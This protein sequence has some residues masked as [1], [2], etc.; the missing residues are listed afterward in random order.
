MDSIAKLRLLTA[1]ME[2]ESAEDNECPKISARKQDSVNLSH[3]TLPNGTTIKL[4]KTLLTSFCER[5]CYYCPFRSGRDFQRATFSP[6]DFADLSMFLYKKRIIDGI[7]LS[8]GII[9]TGTFTQDQLIKTAEIL[10]IKHNFRGYLHLKI[11]PGSDFGQIERAMQLANRVSINLEAPNPEKLEF[12]A[13]KKIFLKELLQP[14]IWINDIRLQQPPYHAWN[15][16]WPSSVTQFV[17]GAGGESDL[18]LLKTTV[19]LYD[20]LNLGRVYYSRFNPIR[21]T[22]LENIPPTPI[23][24]EHRLYQASYLLR[25]YNFSLEELPFSDCGNLPVERDPKLVWAEINLSN[26]PV[27]INKAEYIELLRIPGIGPK[28]AR[29]IINSRKIHPLIFLDDLKR[30]GINQNRAAPY[31]LLNG[32]RPA[33]QYPLF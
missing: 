31:I 23:E 19:Y 17:V 21:D 27:E 24:R 1:Q 32:K 4:L 16:R 15:G 3:A 30:L 7:F 14:L 9:N 5:N 13:P 28:S 22:P 25:D 33:S 6:Q 12:L 2:F 18:E 26:Q 8:S 10:R 20:R 29:S 11:M